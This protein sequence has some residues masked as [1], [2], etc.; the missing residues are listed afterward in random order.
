MKIQDC[1]DD[2]EVMIDLFDVNLAILQRR[3][4]GDYEAVEILEKALFNKSFH[5]GFGSGPILTIREVKRI[6]PD[7]QN[8]P[9]FWIEI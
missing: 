3:R 1:D 5:G 7:Y 6:F 2:Y 4:N 8:N 9:P